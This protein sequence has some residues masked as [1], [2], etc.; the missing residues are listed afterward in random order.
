MM[1]IDDQDF[2][3]NVSS[4]AK[5]IYTWNKKVHCTLEKSYLYDNGFAAI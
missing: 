3:K 4:T 5:V 2:N 1:S